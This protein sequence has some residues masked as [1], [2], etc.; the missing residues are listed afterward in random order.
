[1]GLDITAYQNLQ[2]VRELTHEER[3][4]GGVKDDDSLVTLWHFNSDFPD[5]EE[6]LPKYTAFTAENEFGFR[7]GSYS[8][9]NHWRDELA[10]LAGHESDKAA[11]K[12]GADGKPFYELINFADNEGVI[13]PKIAAKLAKD[14]ADNQAKADAHEDE[15]FRERYGYWRKAFEMAAQNGAVEFH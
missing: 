3:D 9:Y 4:W 14:F 8:G 10:K 13:G 2:A 11:W 7:A 6:G 5:H 12:N 1:M 15:Y